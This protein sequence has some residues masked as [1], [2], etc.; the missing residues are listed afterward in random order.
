MYTF[1]LILIAALLSSLKHSLHYSTK[2]VKYY[3]PWCIIMYANGYDSY[4]YYR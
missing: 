3:M 4:N 2:Y 1:T